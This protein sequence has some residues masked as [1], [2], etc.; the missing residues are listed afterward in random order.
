MNY[1]TKKTMKQANSRW[2]LALSLVLSLVSSQPGLALAASPEA[3]STAPSP[4][5]TVLNLFRD[6]REASHTE[7]VTTKGLVNT[8][9]VKA[10][11]KS[12]TEENTEE[13]KAPQEKKPTIKTMTVDITAYASNVW[14]CDDSPFTTA[15]GSL[16]RDGIVATNVL[17]FGT[18]FRIP[19][20][21]G[22]KIFEVHD[23]MNSRYSYRVDI[24]M[25]KDKEVTK[26]G[27]KRNATI[28]IVEMG[29]GKTQWA[30]WTK[31]KKAMQ[32]QEQALRQEMKLANATK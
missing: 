24:W 18:K 31:N 21:F 29:D 14:E 12:E 25:M 32:E 28:E 3:S 23:R 22:D 27:L 20:Y 9:F 2:L 11:T 7:V 19:K 26:W 6:V 1:H 13:E 16:V 8:T 5:Q 4:V 30:Q 10:P 15:D 17:P